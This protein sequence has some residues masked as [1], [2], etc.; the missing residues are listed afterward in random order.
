MSAVLIAQ[1]LA[2]FGPSAIQL[3]TQLIALA[4]SNS[5]VTA[6]QWTAL[7][8]SLQVKPIDVADAALKSAGVD[9]TTPAAQA[10][11]KLAQ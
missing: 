4:E 2:T 3:V 11:E 1:L 9:T 6:A 5:N 10:I 7:I 8:A